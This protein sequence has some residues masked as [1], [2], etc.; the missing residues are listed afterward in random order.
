MK[1]RHYVWGLVFISSASFSSITFDTEQGALKLYGDVEFNL[2]G[3]SRTGQITSLKKP[4]LIKTGRQE[5]R[6]AGTSMAEF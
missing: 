1:Y 6:N 2:D 3:A 4:V 5:K